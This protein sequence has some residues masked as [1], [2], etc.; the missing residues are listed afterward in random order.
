M[1]LSLQLL[2]PINGL[3]DERVCV[4]DSLW[5]DSN[6]VLFGHLI[7]LSESRADEGWED[8]P[9]RPTLSP[10]PIPPTTW[11]MINTEDGVEITRTDH[12]DKELTFLFAS[13]LAKLPDAAASSCHNRA[14]LAFMRALPFDTPVIL[15]W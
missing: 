3:S 15:M 4:K 13:E 2:V 8:I 1:G 12:Y 14:V 5:L 11:L 9:E 7:D 6:S 10:R